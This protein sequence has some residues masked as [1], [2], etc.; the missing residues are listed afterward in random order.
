MNDSK[1]V[2]SPSAGVAGLERSVLCLASTRF[3]AIGAL[4]ALLACAAVD[5]VG[6]LSAIDWY[7]RRDDETF[8]LAADPL[9]LRITTNFARVELDRARAS[10][11]HLHAYVVP[12]TRL[13]AMFAATRNKAATS[14]T[15]VAQHLD[16]LLTRYADQDLVIVC[17]RQGGRSNY[18]SLLRQTFDSWSLEVLAEAAERSEYRLIDGSRS[19]RLIFAEKAESLSISVAIASMLAKY[20]R[21][22][23][24]ARFN[25]YWR[26]HD[27]TLKPTAG[28]W[29]DGLR[30]LEELAPTLTRLGID[31]ATLT[32]QR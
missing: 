26:A 17:D 2:Y 22:A 6:E 1:K 16:A 10:I 8:P 5:S 15:F 12:E 32:R 9:A 31:P 30:F 19:A 23:T 28:Y 13:N 18:G 7:R 11:V 14:F 4:D 20:L 24:M 21:E 27:P 25:A 29:T 3:D